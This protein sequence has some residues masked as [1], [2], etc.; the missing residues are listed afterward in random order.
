[1][2]VCVCERERER[3]YGIQNTEMLLNKAIAPFEKRERGRCVC[4][5][6]RDRERERDVCCACVYQYAASE[7]PEREMF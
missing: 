2:C 1:M 4:A 6:E 5:C 7:D 3:E